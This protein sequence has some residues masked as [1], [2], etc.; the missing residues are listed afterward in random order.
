MTCTHTPLPFLGVAPSTKAASALERNRNQTAE[1]AL[2]RI[3]ALQATGHPHAGSTS[4]HHDESTPHFGIYPVYLD[5]LATLATTA[6]EQCCQ[7]CPAPTVLVTCTPPPQLLI[8]I[9]P[10][11]VQ[12]TVQE[13]PLFSAQVALKGK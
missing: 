4:L 7:S 6:C 5:C 10:L 12:L 11:T 3:S 9:T 13:V 1:Q 2:A 8:F